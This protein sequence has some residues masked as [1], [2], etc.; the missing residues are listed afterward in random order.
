MA[1]GF[2]RGAADRG[3]RV[4]FGDGKKAVWDQFSAPVFQG[5]PNIAPKESRFLK[6]D[7]IEWVPFYRG[8]RQYNRI[9]S[10]NKHWIW[11]YDFRPI[12][13]ELFF[14]MDETRFAKRATLSKSFVVIE[15]NLPPRKK[16]SPNKD[17]SFKRYLDL[18]HKLS[19]AG[20]EIVQFVY[21][22]GKRIPGAKVVFTPSFRLG[23]ATLRRA[24]LYIGPEGGMHHA[25]AALDVK[26]VVL[27]G[28]FVPPQVTGYDKHINLTHE[29]DF[30]GSLLPCDHCKAAMARI[31]VDEVF[32][33]AM[34]QLG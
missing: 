25:S 5:N 15:P 26:A 10:D 30:C 34:G 16:S 2:A 12:P 33:A 6:D 27:F 24:A 9:S 7:R 22:T 32:D 19:A 1:T 28:G 31:S 23:F 8:H 11:N 29:T 14:T 18:A 21:G 20:I 4:Q 17:W 3:K 13:G